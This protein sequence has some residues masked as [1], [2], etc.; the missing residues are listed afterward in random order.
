MLLV[1]LLNTRKY[2]LVLISYLGVL[3]Y[4]GLVGA[5]LARPIYLLEYIF[6]ISIKFSNLLLSI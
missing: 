2:V 6:T 5:G 4:L 1:L 3:T